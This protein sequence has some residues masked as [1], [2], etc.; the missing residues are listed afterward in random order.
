VRVC[1]N[2]Y[3]HV[4]RFDRRIAE[5]TCHLRMNGMA[6]TA[7]EERVGRNGEKERERESAVS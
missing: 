3:V 6:C 4:H 5:S 1:V 2:G 7:R